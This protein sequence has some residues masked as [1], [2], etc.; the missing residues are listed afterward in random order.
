MP[1]SY[2]LPVVVV[3]MPRLL[4][5]AT[6]VD[7]RERPTLA[8][9]RLP[10][11]ERRRWPRSPRPNHK[12]RFPRSLAVTEGSE[13]MR[14]AVSASLLFSPAVCSARARSGRTHLARATASTASSSGSSSRSTRRP[15]GRLC[16]RSPS[17]RHQA[18]HPRH[19]VRNRA[20]GLPS[21]RP[22]RRV[23]FERPS[24]S[25][26]SSTHPQC[27]RRNL[28]RTGVPLRESR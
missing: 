23:Q 3:N 17:R 26:A 1:G 14:R 15:I 5:Q 25:T 21:G 27:L 19:R 20:H 12:A 10:L 28:R 6:A 18:G 24:M 9:A 4:S 7:G 11:Q 16:R 22:R 8:L 2:Y 13:S